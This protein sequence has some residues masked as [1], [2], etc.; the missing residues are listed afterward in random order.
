[1]GRRVRQV[2]P[3]TCRRRTIRWRPGVHAASATGLGIFSR[4]G[5]KEAIRAE[6]TADNTPAVRA[7]G[8][9]F[10]IGV[11]GEGGMLGV[12]ARGSEGGILATG[13]VEGSF[14]GMV[15]IYGELTKSGGGFR[16]DHPADAENKY[17]PHSFVESDPR[18][19][20]YDGTKL[21]RDRDSPS[22]V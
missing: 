5:G 16:I 22:L 6:T 15:R 17:L 9:P 2:G 12:E 14:Y 20:I 13:R 18:L 10:G 1:M 3:R 19:N 11:T 4:S 7:I 8:S 21:L